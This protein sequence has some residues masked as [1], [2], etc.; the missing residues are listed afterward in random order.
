MC[1]RLVDFDAHGGDG[2][3]RGWIIAMIHFEG[4]LRFGVGGLPFWLVV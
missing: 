1:L 4:R 3:R 2:R